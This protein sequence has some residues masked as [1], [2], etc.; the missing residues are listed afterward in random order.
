M[1][2]L[3]LVA[4]ILAPNTLL[5]PQLRSNLLTWSML[6]LQGM[7]CLAMSAVQLHELAKNA[8]PPAA[9]P[10][11]A[12]SKPPAWQA[13]PHWPLLGITLLPVLIGST[14]QGAALLWPSLATMMGCLCIHATLWLAWQKQLENTHLVKDIASNQLLKHFYDLPFAGMATCSLNGRK[15]QHCNDKLC[16][17]VGYSQE[18]LINLD[19]TEISHPDDVAKEV[20]AFQKIL[21][22]QTNGY[23]QEKRFIRKGGEIVYATIDVHGIYNPDGSLQ[24]VAALV[25]DI[26]EQKRITQQLL[27]SEQSYHTLADSAPALIWTSGPDKLCNYFNKVWLNF[28]GR[29]LE[30]ELGN[31]W[32]EGVHPDD[33]AYCLEYYL[34]HFDQRL[35]FNM[36]YRLRHHS[37]EY[38]WIRD[39]GCPRYSR[40]GTFLGYIGYC[41]DVTDRV[42][43]Q[44]ALEESEARLRTIV[45]N[46]PM[47]LCTIDKN[48]IFTMSDGNGLKALG[49]K[50]GEVVGQSVYTLYASHPEIL[51]YINLAMSGEQIR[52]QT[53]I[54]NILYDSI[55]CP[56]PGI[57]STSGVMIT[58]LDITERRNAETEQQR[59]MARIE[60]LLRVANFHA[61]N[62]QHLLDYIL[63]QAVELSQSTA[64]CIFIRDKNHFTLSNITEEADNAF[65]IPAQKIHYTLEDMVYFHEAILQG[66]PIIRNATNGW[67]TK[68]TS[69]TDIIQLLSRH[70]CIPLR[71]NGT[72]QAILVLANKLGNYEKADATQ[73]TQFMISAWNMVEQ[74]QAEDQF[75]RISDLLNISQ[76]LAHVGGWDFNPHDNSL[77]WTDENYRIFEIPP[78]NYEPKLDS[79]LAFF[80]PESRARRDI[81]FATAMA[82]GTGF[83]LELELDTAQGNRR[84]IRATCVVVKN[85]DT[86][87]RIIGALLDITPYKTIEAELRKHKENLEELVTQRTQELMQALDTAERATR[88]KSAFLAT[89]SH[90]IRTPIT[91]VL[92]MT[93][94][95]LQTNPTP[96]QKG[97]LEK[98]SI[99]ANLLLGIINDILDFSK[100]EAGRL[101]LSSSEFVLADVLDKIITVI[102]LKA[103]E[104]KLEFLVKI[105]QDTPYTLIGDATRLGQILLNLCSNAVKFT[106]QGEIILEI[107]NAPG[108]KEDLVEMTFKVRDTGIGLSPEQISLL[109]RPFSQAD[110]SNARRF[111]GTGLGLAICKQL[112]E[113]MDGYISVESEPEHGSTFSFSIPCKRGQKSTLPQPYLV[114]DMQML[115]VLVVD[116]NTTVQ[117]ILHDLLLRFDYTVI[118]ADSAH[119]ACDRLAQIPHPHVH[120]LLADWKEAP[121]DMHALIELAKQLNSNTKVIRMTLGAEQET[122]QDSDR[123]L[124][125][126]EIIKPITASTLF[127]A[128][129]NAFGKEHFASTQTPVNQPHRR[130]SQPLLGNKI[131]LA[132]DNAFNQQVIQEILES[133]GFEIVIAEN[134][135]IALDLVSAEHFDAILMDV[136]MPIMD[137]LEATLRIRKGPAQAQIPIIA[138]TAHAMIEEQRRCLEAGMSDF[139]TKPIEP[140]TLIAKLAFWVSDKDS[141]HHHT[142]SA[143]DTLP[144]TEEAWPAEPSP[145]LSIETGLRYC[146]NKPDFYI[147]ILKEFSRNHY[148]SA[149][150]L[151]EALVHN[152]PDAA[153][154]LAHSLKSVAASIGAGSLSDTAAALE[155]SIQNEPG[156]DA[157]LLIERLDQALSIAMDAIQ[158][159]ISRWDASHPPKFPSTEGIPSALE[160]TFL[161]RDR[162][163]T[164]L[165]EALERLP[166]LLAATKNGPASNLSEAL[167]EA[168]NSFELER[169]KSVLNSLIIQLESEEAAP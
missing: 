156:A 161:I 115:T 133:A 18:E 17:I 157:S 67:Q 132:E 24:C 154:I 49:L 23:S 108:I 50:P 124:S 32:A 109:F 158:A 65:V 135:Q 77:Y 138:M 121:E 74:R 69:S 25:H 130:Q 166:D 58:S 144:S 51:K 16:E 43:A 162:L 97:Y 35:N 112:V 137:G 82:E 3:F 168:L 28:T 99:S 81:A 125:D 8:A 59:N 114:K 160:S 91:A 103:A 45:R 111:G 118:C 79:T 147:K 30:Q 42:L 96:K 92:G 68:A 27:D 142:N 152:Q 60:S 98:I 31:G 71:A 34:S 54:N 11:E 119:Q 9:P 129:M 26:T 140:E 122:S 101:E 40:S 5:L 15:L 87:D 37:G 146:N 10:S 61:R 134:G 78:E 165:G 90:E 141:R 120:V 12:A 7:G 106:D 33:F 143:T 123:W 167:C 131:L 163:E 21:Q 136:Q 89:M 93:H 73:L 63:H 6:L 1:Y 22:G 20:E 105:E 38:R 84:Q 48:G 53:T 148:D 46:L 2:G 13:W 55:Y 36:D 76:K 159:T 116:A 41:L 94:L 75:V 80:T 70:L 113:L 52:G 139:M 102:S 169:A 83:D 64:G 14:A 145:A 4:W 44:K 72:T 86:I 155:R 56:I 126:A 62:A 39:S 29:S 127:D 107:S 150:R 47:V 66:T 149:D 153:R 151:Q 19:W 85:G 117:N 164:D 104:K 88:G 100:I 95:A 110:S 128:I 57:E